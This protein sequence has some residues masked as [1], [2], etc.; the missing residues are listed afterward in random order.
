[1]E[2]NCP[3]CNKTFQNKEEMLE[4]YSLAHPD[5]N[6]PEQKLTKRPA[7]ITVI[8]IVWFL[9]GLYNLYSAYQAVSVDVDS[10]KYLNGYGLSKWFNFGI[11]AELVLS[12]TIIV[13]SLIQFG[14]VFGLLTAKRYSYKFALILPIAILII[15]IATLGLYLSA[16]SEIGLSVNY[17]MFGGLIGGGVVWTVI[18]WQYLRK[19]HVKSYL[20]IA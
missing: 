7:G 18:Y 14:T 5:D 13:L 9:F 6:M 2:V 16:P 11:P 12:L 10:L 15:N 17:S 20:G 4:H 19:P 8:S 3:K 1:M